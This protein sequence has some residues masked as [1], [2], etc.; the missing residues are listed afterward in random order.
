MSELHITAGATE[1][2][3]GWDK[4]HTKN[5]GF[6]P[7]ALKDMPQS[8]W[9]GMITNSR[10]KIWNQLENCQKFVHKLLKNTCILHALV[11]QTFYGQ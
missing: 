11:D 10:R 1:K 5:H 3:P 2:L 9:K 8:E 7:T 4:L 6:G